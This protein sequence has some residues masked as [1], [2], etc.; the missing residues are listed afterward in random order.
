MSLYVIALFL[1]WWIRD[2][3]YFTAKEGVGY[4]LGVAG[5][6]MLLLQFAY[7]LRK[8]VR[9]MNAWGPTRH[10][11]RAHKMLGLLGPTLILY[12]SNFRLHAT[13]S[14]V[15]LFSM[16]VVVASGLIGRFIY[17]KIHSSHYGRML[18][19]L[20]LQNELGFSRETL[21]HEH[22]VGVLVKYHLRR[23]EVEASMPTRGPIAGAW[24]LLTLGH[25]MRKA[26]SRAFEQLR[27]DLR[28]MAERRQ[29]NSET[30]RTRL[31]HERQLVDTYLVSVCRVSEFSTYRR[32]FSYWHMLHIPLF[33]MLVVTGVVHVITVHM[34]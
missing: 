23:F 4:A 33:V 1:G 7:P 6:A 14:N 21:E 25:R 31:R 10:W 34:Y 11:F 30:L 24:R 28:R 22:C 29:W 17:V 8:N 26:R 13:N 27:G 19:L 2:E 9:F 16:L 5:G 20:E 3:D 12:H 18:S 15:A 32:L